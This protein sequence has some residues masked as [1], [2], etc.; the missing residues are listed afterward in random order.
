MPTPKEDSSKKLEVKVI[1]SEKTIY[2]GTAKSVSSE[3]EQGRFDVLPGHQSFISIIQ[4][5]ILIQTSKNEK[6]QLRIG[7]GILKCVKNNV[8]ILVGLESL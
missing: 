2:S 1:A 8:E 3:N 4:R 7:K 6:V 5:V